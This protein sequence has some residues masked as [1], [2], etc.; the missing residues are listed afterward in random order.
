MD[1]NQYVVSEESLDDK[2]LS[3]V[4]VYQKL[5]DK[6][7]YLTHTRSDIVVVVQCYFYALSF[8]I[9]SQ[10]CDAC[11]KCLSSKGFV[12]GYRIFFG[13]S[14]IS[15]KNKKHNT[16][17]RSFADSEYMTISIVTCEIIWIMKILNVLGVSGL[18]P[19][20]VHCDS[21]PALLRGHVVRFDNSK[22]SSVTTPPEAFGTC[23]D[24]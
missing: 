19:V 9:T 13:S 16:I 8:G 2:K 23:R 1:Q 17:S 14:L 20:E 7:I 18:T 11:F 10:T 21:K 24:P 22:G 3:N 12:I 4:T 5:V 6:L 15:W